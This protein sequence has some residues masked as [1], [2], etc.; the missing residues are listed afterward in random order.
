MMPETNSTL[1][2]H[3][4]GPTLVIVAWFFA[5]VSFVVIAIR[6]YVKLRI[7]NRFRTDDWLIV[8]TY[9]L[10]IC[11]SIF[12]TISVHWGLGRHIQFL[13]P[14]QIKLSIKYVYLCEFF[15]IM[16]PCFGRISYAFLLL[17]IIPPTIGPKRFLWTIIGIQF[18][19]DCQPI[20]EFWGPNSKDHCWDPRVQQYTGFFQESVC[21]A[22]DLVLACFPASLFWK[23]QMKISTKISLSILMGLGVLRDVRFGYLVLEA[24]MVLLAASIPTL[25]PLIRGVSTGSSRGN[26]GKSGSYALRKLNQTTVGSSSRDD[27]RFFMLDGETPPGQSAEGLDISIGKGSIKD[28]VEAKDGINKTTTLTISD[29]AR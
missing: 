24:Y 12:C 2:T 9:A 18:V 6:A 29:R 1:A 23:L 19:V 5:A 4:L 15:S 13:N 27:G 11:N 20:Y 26:S 7:V 16:S 21:S 14:E 17:Q 8:F 3:N 10:A 28:D 25:R 22:V